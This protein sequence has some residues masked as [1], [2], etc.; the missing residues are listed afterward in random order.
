MNIIQMAEPAPP[1]AAQDLAETEMFKGVSSAGLR[2]A[3]RRARVRRLARNVSVFAQGSSAERA[4]LLLSGR[5]R[6]AQRDTDG[7]QL[8]VR[9]IGPG[10]MFGTVGLFTDHTYPADAVTD[11]ASVE[12]SW[13]EKDL[14]KLVETYP[15]LALNIINVIGSRLREVQERLRELAIQR[16]G[17]RIA[18]V[19]L[20][21]AE[22][23]G[24]RTTKGA[25]IDFPLSRKDVAEMCGATLHTVSRILTGWEKAGVLLTSQ[26]RVTILDIAQLR[27]LAEES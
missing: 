9:F 19:L 13:S 1:P 18:H 10:K 20:R 2:D 21:L 22:Q 24:R 11:V 16:V 8:L 17:R 14:L 26:Q 7:G 25:A 5:I 27:R 12:L 23:A 3:L 4:H 15:R 6:I